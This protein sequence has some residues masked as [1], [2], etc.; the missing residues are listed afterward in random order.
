M[1]TARKWL[2]ATTDKTSGE[3]TIGDGKMLLLLAK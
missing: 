2:K 3:K 1:E